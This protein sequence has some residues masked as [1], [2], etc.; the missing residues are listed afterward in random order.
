MINPNS[1]S[2]VPGS[3]VNLSQTSTKRKRG[4]IDHPPH[5]PAT[6]QHLLQAQTVPMKTTKGAIG[7]SYTRF[8]LLRRDLPDSKTRQSSI[9]CLW[10]NC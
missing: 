7:H 5:P 4:R 1:M 9:P 8:G 3:P 2:G 10:S 6:H